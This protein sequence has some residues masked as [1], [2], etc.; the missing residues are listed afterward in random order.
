MAENDCIGSK[1]DLKTDL[2]DQNRKLKIDIPILK[3]ES[4]EKLRTYWDDLKTS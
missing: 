3:T 1:W 4:Y 2:R